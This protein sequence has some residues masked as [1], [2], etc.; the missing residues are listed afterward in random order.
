MPLPR[1][2]SEAEFERL[3]P[4]DSEMAGRFDW[5]ATPVGPEKS[6]PQS[7]RIA[8]GIMLNSRYPMFVWAF[9]RTTG[10]CS[11]SFTVTACACSSW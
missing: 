5:A 7:L 9:S 2:R 1:G 11:P 4:G 10:N 8:V 3:F 6:W